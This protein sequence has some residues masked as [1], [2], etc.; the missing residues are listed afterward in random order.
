MQGRTVGQY[1]ILEQLGSGGMGIV[2]KAH[3]NKLVDY[4]K[5]ADLTIRPQVQYAR[6]RI[7]ALLDQKAR[8]PR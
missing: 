3:D 8:E 2:Y 4:W 6:E 1:L 7:D 5:N